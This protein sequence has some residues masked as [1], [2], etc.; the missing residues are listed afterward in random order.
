VTRSRAHGKAPAAAGPAPR[1]WPPG[2][3]PLAPGTSA[4]ALTVLTVLAT[5]RARL[6][7]DQLARALGWQLPRTSAVIAA[8]QDN[9]TSAAPAGAAASPARNR[10]VTPR[11]DILT[12]AQRH[13][14]RDTTGTGV[15][16]DDQA[17]VLLAAL[18]AGQS[19]AYAGLRAQPG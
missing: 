9:P 8:A 7:A 5:A 12:Q 16:N 13:A 17:R 18:A 10:T 6:S 11:L 1:P 19:D 14:L 3:P 15:L 4:D 2:Q